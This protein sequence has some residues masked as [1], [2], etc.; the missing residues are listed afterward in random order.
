MIANPS[1]RNRKFM[2]LIMSLDSM[3]GSTSAVAAKS[4]RR[5]LRQI[6]AADSTRERPNPN[7]SR[8][9]PEDFRLLNRNPPMKSTTE[10]TR[11]DAAP[12]S[13]SST[14]IPKN[15]VSSRKV[16]PVTKQVALPMNQRIGETRML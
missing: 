11:L 6:S 4:P 3:N 14:S 5:K 13:N 7:R 8:P 9:I 1:P 2:S 16:G 10:Q 15:G 12:T